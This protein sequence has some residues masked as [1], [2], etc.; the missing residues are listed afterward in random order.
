M[1]GRDLDW[2]W[3]SFYY[4]TW[5]L[6]Q[7]VA[8]VESGPSGPVVTIEDRGYAPMPALVRIQTTRG[9]TLDRTVPVET[10]LGGAVR[11]EIALPASVGEVTRVEI[12]PGTLFPDV[13]RADNVWSATGR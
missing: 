1:A 3:R 13:Q 4:E 2:F 6:D 9:G 7:A 12:D 8:G 5:T 10:W 11:A